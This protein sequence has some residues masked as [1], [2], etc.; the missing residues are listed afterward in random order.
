MPIKEDAAEKALGGVTR[1]TISGSVGDRQAPCAPALG[2]FPRGAVGTRR[3]HFLGAHALRR[4]PRLRGN[5]HHGRHRDQDGKEQGLRHRILHQGNAYRVQAC[6]G[7]C[8]TNCRFPLVLLLAEQS[9]DAH[10]LGI[11]IDKL[12]FFGH[13]VW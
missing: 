10:V 9:E 7:Y 6:Q 2:A 5:R 4:F 13:T 1:G 3:T 12:T 8:T 11:H